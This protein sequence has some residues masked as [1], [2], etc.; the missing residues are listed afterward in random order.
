[1]GHIS[2]LKVR[3]AAEYPALLS[4]SLL[5]YPLH[6]AK[7][8]PHYRDTKITEDNSYGISTLLDIQGDSEIHPCVEEHLQDCASGVS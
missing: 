3:Q 7:T 6:C 5:L 1:M 8:I 4:W 2:P